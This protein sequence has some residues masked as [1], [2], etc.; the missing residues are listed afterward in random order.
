ME[1]SKKRKKAIASGDLMWMQ[2]TLLDRRDTELDVPVG[3]K[4]CAETIIAKK[5]RICFI[6]LG[7]ILFTVKGIWWMI[8]EFD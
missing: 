2:R 5:A 8:Y 4:A 3:A 7:Y 6:I 1:Q